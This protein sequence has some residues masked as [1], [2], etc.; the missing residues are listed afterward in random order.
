V[1][2]GV[3]LQMNLPFVEPSVKSIASYISSSFAMKLN[4]SAQTRFSDG[5]RMVS[6]LF[7]KASIVEPFVK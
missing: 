7:G 4:S 3:E 5:P 1:L 6:G 2:H